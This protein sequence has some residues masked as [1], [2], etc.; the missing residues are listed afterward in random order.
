MVDQMQHQPDQ[1]VAMNPRPPLAARAERAAGA[2]LEGQ[3]H[4]PQRAAAWPQYDAN[5]DSRETNA[6]RLD[7]ASF[8]LPGDRDVSQEVVTGGG[9]LGQLFLCAIAVE[10]DRAGRNHDL[11]FR[12]GLGDPGHQVS[13]ADDPAVANGVFLGLA[14]SAD[15]RFSRQMNHRVD[16][17]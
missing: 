16:A 9:L 8:L 1:V 3:E 10:A 14:P 15:D 13:R 5:T 4:G 11:G 7:F 12:F 2:Q 17:G 6:E